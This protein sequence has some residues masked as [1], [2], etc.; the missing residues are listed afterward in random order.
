M[1][2]EET[3]NSARTMGMHTIGPAV[4]HHNSPKKA[5][6][7]LSLDY[8]RVP[9]LH[10]HLKLQHLHRR[11]LWLARKIPQQKEVEVWVKELRGNPLQK[12]AE[13]GNTN[14]NEDNE[15][16]RSELL[17]DVPEWLQDFKENLVDKN[18]Q[19]HQYSVPVLLM[20]FQWSCEQKWNGVRANMVS[21]RTFRRTQIAISAWGR[22]LQGLLAEDVLVQLCPKRKILVT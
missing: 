21:T 7:S 4:E 17:E 14:E 18:V 2:L 13:T 20:N 8:Q 22:N 12:P 3:G 1:L 9:L 10:L 6:H 5:Y 16:L 19:P 11:N 15:E